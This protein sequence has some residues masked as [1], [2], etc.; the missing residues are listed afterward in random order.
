VTIQDIFDFLAA[1]SAGD[2]AADENHTCNVST[3]DI[4]DF[5][6]GY[7]VSRR[8]AHIPASGSSPSAQVMEVMHCVTTSSGSL[9][10]SLNL[11][12]SAAKPCLTPG[13]F[14]TPVSPAPHPRTA[15]RRGRSPPAAQPCGGGFV[16]A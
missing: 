1:F 10:N 5:L 12:P 16:A 4:N 7:W 15:L 3:Q 6:A 13:T 14:P 11:P 2:P 8:A 9:I